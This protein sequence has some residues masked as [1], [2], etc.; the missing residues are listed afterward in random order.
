MVWGN[1]TLSRRTFM[2]GFLSVLRYDS[3]GASLAY[4]SS[5]SVGSM[6]SLM[7]RWRRHVKYW[8]PLRTLSLLFAAVR[9]SS[10]QREESG[11]SV[12]RRLPCKCRDFRL[13]RPVVVGTGVEGSKGEGG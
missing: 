8:T 11:C 3:S 7:S 1:Y 2:S 9:T 10:E 12:L 5:S 6:L 4:A 13:T